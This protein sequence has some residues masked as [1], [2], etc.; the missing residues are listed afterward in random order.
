MNQ[1]GSRLPSSQYQMPRDTAQGSAD[2][3]RKA[4]G[5]TANLR[6][7]GHTAP[8]HL[9]GKPALGREQLLRLQMGGA[10][11]PGAL[12]ARDSYSQPVTWTREM[13]LCSTS[14]NH[15]VYNVRVPITAGT[16]RARLRRRRL[17]KMPRTRCWWNL[18]CWL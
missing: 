12:P 5:K 11:P 18:L 1:T 3:S 14:T 13:R 4:K 6:R 2:L 17:N 9:G 7:L 15:T 16:W 10:A 8:P